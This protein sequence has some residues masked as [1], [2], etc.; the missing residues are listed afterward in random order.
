M[1]AEQERLKKEEQERKEYE[2]YLKLKAEFT[3]EES[4]DVAI[5]SE[6]EVY[7]FNF[8]FIVFVKI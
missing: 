7:F 6:T 5:L 4:G 1:K 8:F 2:E 3:I